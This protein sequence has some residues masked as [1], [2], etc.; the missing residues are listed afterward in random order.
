MIKMY[1][2]PSNKTADILHQI[3]LRLRQCYSLAEEGFYV[4]H[5]IAKLRL[6]RSVVEEKHQAILIERGLKTGTITGWMHH[7]G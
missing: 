7:K 5:L 1:D 4:N 6:E 2:H 3:D